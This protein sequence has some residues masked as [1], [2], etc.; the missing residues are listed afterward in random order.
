MSGLVPYI[1][2]GIAML[3]R[4]FSCIAGCLLLVGAVGSGIMAVTGVGF[5]VGDK[6]LAEEK[7]RGGVVGRGGGVCCCRGRFHGWNR[8]GEGLSALCI[9][10]VT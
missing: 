10:A 9:F 8:V 7:M 6:K 4:S 5:E 1:N 2:E 3:A